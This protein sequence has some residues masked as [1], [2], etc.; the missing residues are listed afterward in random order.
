[1]ENKFKRSWLIVGKRGQK[2]RWIKLPCGTEVWRCVYMEMRLMG[3]GSWSTSK[4]EQ[5]FLQLDS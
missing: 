4:T 2:T 1:M 3:S 5:G